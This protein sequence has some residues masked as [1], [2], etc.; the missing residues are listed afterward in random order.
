[1]EFQNARQAV[2]GKLTETMANPE[3][4]Q[5]NGEFLGAVLDALAVG[6]TEVSGGTSI[7]PDIVS[8][9]IPPEEK[10]FPYGMGVG[11]IHE[12]LTPGLYDCTFTFSQ[13]IADPNLAGGL[14]VKAR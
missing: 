5:S 10:T 3:N 12:S 4:L 9:A 6:V 14:T 7:L 8:G 1:M 11:F 2:V 13:G